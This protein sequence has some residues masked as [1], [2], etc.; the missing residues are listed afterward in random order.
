MQAL[1]CCV[2]GLGLVVAATACGGGGDERDAGADGAGEAPQDLSGELLSLDD[3]DGQW[4]TGG[5]Q[6]IDVA[7]RSGKVTGPCPGAEATSLPN[8]KRSV[9]ASGNATIRF[10]SVEVPGVV[11]VE[12]LSHDPAGELFEALR[13]T[14]DACVGEKWEEGDDPVE[15]TKLEAID[16]AGQGDA[17]VGYRQ[18]W[19]TGGTMTARTSTPWFESAMCPCHSG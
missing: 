15:D 16:L 11:L 6:E 12:E 3:F 10:E 5:P 4:D 9:G 2:L 7:D 14:F 1:T 13:H 8:A 19:G 18:L 17:A